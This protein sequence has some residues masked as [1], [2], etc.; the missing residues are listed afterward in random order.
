MSK[1]R[2]YLLLHVAGFTYFQGI[3]LSLVKY[4]FF[5][6]AC[7]AFYLFHIWSAIIYIMSI[8]ILP[9]LAL[10]I[11]LIFTHKNYSNFTTI[12]RTLLTKNFPQTRKCAL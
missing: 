7:V 10:T 6:C 5:K 3:L 1:S 9:V 11:I 2:E 12:R 4:T 8:Y